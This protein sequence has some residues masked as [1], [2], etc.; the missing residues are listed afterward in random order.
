[1]QGALSHQSL[2]LGGV[3]DSHAY[4]LEMDM[5]MHGV[6]ENFVGFNSGGID[7]LS[8]V[9]RQDVAK[10]NLVSATLFLL[11]CVRRSI[12]LVVFSRARH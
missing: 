7:Q 10:S 12:L 4:R 2:I 9:W 5:C 6:I 11:W 1:M 8:S 3:H